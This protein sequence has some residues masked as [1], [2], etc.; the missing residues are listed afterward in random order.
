M[1]G[2]LLGAGHSEMWTLLNQ[3]IYLGGRNSKLSD[4]KVSFSKREKGE[5]AKPHQVPR[6]IS[7]L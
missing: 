5:S 7:R 6:E 3:R 2:S 1:E 4:Q